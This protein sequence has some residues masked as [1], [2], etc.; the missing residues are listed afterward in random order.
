MDGNGRL[1]RFLMNYLLVTGGHQCGIVPVQRRAVYMAALE[2]ASTHGNIKPF[3]KLIAGLM[4][5]QAKE[6][7]NRAA[8]V[9]ALRPA[10]KVKP[11]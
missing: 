3:A 7:R 10:A 11:N 9:K 8:S 1:G 4:L 6:P 5:E 2:Q